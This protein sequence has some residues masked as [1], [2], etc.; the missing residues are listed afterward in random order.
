SQLGLFEPPSDRAEA[1]ARLKREINERHGR[2]V[3]R[4]A[5]TLPLVGVYRDTSNG[6]DICDVRGKMCF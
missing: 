3:L 2:F 6:Y 4:S 1:V 5:A